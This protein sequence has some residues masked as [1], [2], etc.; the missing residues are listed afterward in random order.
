M[1]EDLYRETLDAMD[2]ALANLSSLVPPPQA[3]PFGDSWVYRHVEQQTEQAIVEKLA[4]IPSGLRAAQILYKTGFF[5]EQA[6]L[7][8]LI[9][10]ISED[11]IFLAIPLMYGGGKPIHEKYLKAFFEEEFDPATG[12]PT[13]QNRPMVPRKKIRAYIAESPIGT[14]NPSS[15]IT[16]S[17]TLSKAYSGYV[18]AASPQIMEM[19][20]GKPPQFHTKGM[21]GTPRE[22]QHRQ[23]LANYFYRSLAAFVI[24]ARALGHQPV[25]DLLFALNKKY[26]IAMGIRE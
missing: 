23:D 24:A 17:R 22:L 14:A 5:Q 19:Y 26:E 18:H 15:H 2:T 21:L 7:Q 13:V 20:G 6:S 25:Y 16:A 3:V 11:I 4:R 12:L 10:E 8:R 1:P 9:D